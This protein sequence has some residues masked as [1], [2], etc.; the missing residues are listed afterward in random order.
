MTKVLTFK[1]EIAGL[2][3]KLW[4]KIE[5]T[6]RRTLA[7]LAYTILASFHSSSYHLYSIKY[8]NKIYDC[9]F[10][11]QDYLGEDIFDATSTKLK[12]LTLKENDKL[13]MNYRDNLKTTFII[14][15]LSSKE[16]IKGN[17]NNYPCIIAGEGTG[18]NEG[19]SI[20]DN[21][22]FTIKSNNLHIKKV[23][24]KI[25]DSYEKECN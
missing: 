13:T 9:Y 16:F 25:K 2:E 19:V 12:S 17:S 6:D 5:I 20:Y 14:T 1:V 10:D 11:M 22:N 3:Q 8:Q 21:Q 7:S 18:I 4:R 23:F 15:Y 24:S